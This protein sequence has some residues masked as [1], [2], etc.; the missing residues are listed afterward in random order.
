MLYR[1]LAPVS[2]KVWDEMEERLMEIFKTHLSA[3]KV[4]KVD[5]P[6][7]KD[8]NVITEGRLDKIEE[9]SDICYSNYKVIPLTEV[10][11]EF[12]M[13]RWELD[14][15]TRGAKDIDYEPL[16]EAAKK[17]ALFED[18]VVYNG[19]KNAKIKG[20]IES[21]EIDEIKFGDDINSILDSVSRGVI[22]LRKSFQE[23]PFTLV[24]GEDAYR[25]IFTQ[26]SNYP[27]DKRIEDLTGSKIVYSHVLDGALLVPYN[28]DDLELTIGQ[29]L[30]IGYQSNDN[31]NVRFFITESFTFR[32]LDPSIIVKYKL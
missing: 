23:G 11:I 27:L 7:G 22:E 30:S 6:N 1:D 20:L 14:N 3:R 17:L 2:K 12:E 19:L 26:G 25:S 9:E 13:G 29:D 10:R 21:A 4:V 18:N 28:H 16:E 15:I 8:Y 5:G 24:V 32:V 31:K